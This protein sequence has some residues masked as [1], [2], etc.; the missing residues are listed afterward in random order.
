MKK[1]NIK[2]LESIKNTFATLSYKGEYKCVKKAREAN[3]V[4]A[5][6]LTD[7]GFK[8]AEK[9]TPCPFAKVVKEST[10]TISLGASLSYKKRVESVAKSN[11]IDCDYHPTQRDLGMFPIFGEMLWVKN[12]LSEVY[13]RCYQVGKPKPKFFADGTEVKKLAFGQ[14]AT[15]DDFKTLSGE[16]VAPSLLGDEDGDIIYAQDEDGNILRDESGEP[17]AIAL[18]P[19]RAIK[20]SNCKV[21]RKGKEIEFLTEEDWDLNELAAIRDAYYAKFEN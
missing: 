21:T 16:W 20:L 2:V 6:A 4:L 11:G 13:I 12:D 17:V 15:S 7:N 9:G 19:L 18:P 10:Y 5:K 14:W 3:E 8:V 1:P